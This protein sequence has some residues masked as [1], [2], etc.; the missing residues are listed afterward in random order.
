LTHFRNEL[1]FFPHVILPGY[2]ADSSDSTAICLA[3]ILTVL[4][5]QIVA[6]NH[7]GEFGVAAWI[8]LNDTHTF[9]NLSL[10]LI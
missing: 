2:R 10:T 4:A 8:S 6:C 7:L 3:P 1:D 5:Y 9:F